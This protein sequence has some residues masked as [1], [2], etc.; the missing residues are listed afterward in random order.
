[1]ISAAS[2]YR[3][4]LDVT[5]RH[6]A[7]KEDIATVKDTIR[8]IYRIGL[9]NHVQCL[10]LCPL[11]CGAFKNP[12]YDVAKFFKEILEEPEFKDKYEAVVFAILDKNQLKVTSIMEIS[13]LSSMFSMQIR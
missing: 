1:M 10:I 9:V 8:T 2:V 3:P 7:D 6:F 12:P 13:S 5:R 4:E 11:G